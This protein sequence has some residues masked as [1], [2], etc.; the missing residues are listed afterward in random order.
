[1]EF[2]SSKWELSFLTVL[3]NE[4]LLWSAIGIQGAIRRERQMVG[5][6][7]EE[8]VGILNPEILSGFVKHGIELIHYAGAKEE[9]VNGTTA[10]FQRILPCV[11]KGG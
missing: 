6:H 11:D 1:L 3:L 8:G 7:E 10:V 9:Q 4:V 2:W 5:I